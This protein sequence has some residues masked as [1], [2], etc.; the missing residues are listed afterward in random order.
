MTKFVACRTWTMSAGS[1]CPKF[2]DLSKWVL[3]QFAEVKY[4][5]AGK[6]LLSAQVIQH[7]WTPQTIPSVAEPSPY[8]TH[9][10]AY[11]LGCRIIDVNGYKE[12]NHT[13][14]RAQPIRFIVA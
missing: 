10:A 6:T 5:P 11:G 1:V 4:G 14:V 7:R 9:F 3:I 2:T 12:V 13:G 8:N